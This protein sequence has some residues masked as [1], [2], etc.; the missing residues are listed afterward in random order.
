MIHYKIT[1]F[2]Y[3]IKAVGEELQTKKREDTSARVSGSR[4][5]THTKSIMGDMTKRP[6]DRSYDIRTYTKMDVDLWLNPDVSEW[7]NK[8]APKTLPTYNF[9]PHETRYMIAN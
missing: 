1:L 3:R 6:P 5:S 7:F 2:N 9:S 4:L 8:D